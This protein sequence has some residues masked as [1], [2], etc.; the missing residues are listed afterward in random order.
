M[1]DLRDILA[2][3]SILAKTWLSGGEYIFILIIMW[4]IKCE[5]NFI[6]I[7]LDI[8]ANKSS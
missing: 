2:A 7:I 8:L 5:L 6:L 1:R 3:K 4:W